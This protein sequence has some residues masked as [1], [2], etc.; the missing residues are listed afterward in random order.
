METAGVAGQDVQA[1]V[2][3]EGPARQDREDDRGDYE[4]ELEP[5]LSGHGEY[6]IDGLK[7]HI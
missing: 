2:D 4:P 1:L 6:L 5:V 3:P 7:C